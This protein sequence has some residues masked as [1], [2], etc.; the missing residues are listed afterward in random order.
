[1]GYSI[2]TEKWRYIEWDDGKR[3]TQLYDEVKDPQE[4]RNL[5]SDPKYAAVLTEMRQWLAKM[6]AEG[7]AATSARGRP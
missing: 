3:G 7:T 6:K 4:L 5:A 1:M 2:R